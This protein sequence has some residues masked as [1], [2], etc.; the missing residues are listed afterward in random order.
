MEK[1][2]RFVTLRHIKGG[3]GSAHVAIIVSTKVGSAVVRNKIKRRLRE[4]L[5]TQVHHIREPGFFLFIAQKTSVKA[6]FDRLE[7]DVLELLHWTSE[8]P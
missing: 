8:N 6:K 1:T 4:I 3:T 2:G 7:S 5:R